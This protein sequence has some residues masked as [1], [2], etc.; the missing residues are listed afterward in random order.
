MSNCTYFALVL[1][2]KHSPT[3]KACIDNWEKF[4]QTCFLKYKFDPNLVISGEIL[5]KCFILKLGKKK[6]KT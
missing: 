6:K 3:I 2:L 5:A 4:A 1:R